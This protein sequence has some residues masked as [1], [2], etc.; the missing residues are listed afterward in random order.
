MDITSLCRFWDFCHYG[1]IRDYHPP[2]DTKNRKSFLHCN[3]SLHEENSSCTITYLAGI[4]CLR[5]NKSSNGFN[6]MI[7]RSVFSAMR[8]SWFG[9]CTSS[10]GPILL[11][12]WLQLP[13]SSKGS[14]WSDPIINRNCNGCLITCLRVNKLKY[15]PQVI[16]YNKK[17]DESS[18]TNENVTLIV[19]RV[20]KVPWFEQEWSHPW[21]YQQQ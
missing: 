4:S 6:I 11:K 2:E 14:A 17:M 10:C 12:H 7:K 18:V 3:T 9:K 8:H 20:W 1:F 21:I 13:K 16:D 15:K 5:Q 19:W